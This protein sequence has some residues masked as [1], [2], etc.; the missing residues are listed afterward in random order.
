MLLRC[1]ASFLIFSIT[2]V[3]EDEA[4]H[5]WLEISLRPYATLMHQPESTW[6]R[7]VPC[8]WADSPLFKRAPI[9]LRDL[10][11]KDMWTWLRIVLCF[12]VD[13]PLFKRAPINLR[14]S[15]RKDMRTW[16]RIV[17]CF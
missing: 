11:R 17:P 8:F 12:W 15:E 6:L 16:L 5:G 2:Y 13:S 10:E 9:N 14:D 1:L 4:H 7:T 3:P